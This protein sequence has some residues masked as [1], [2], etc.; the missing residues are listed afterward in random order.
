MRNASE[1]D[2]IKRVKRRMDS[3]L[4]LGTTTIECK[5]GYGLN[6][7][8]ELKSLKVI[9]EVGNSHPIEMVP[10]FYGRTCFPI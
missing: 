9:H 1:L 8:S 3:F 10:T 7:E 2:L 6:T 4:S 5:S